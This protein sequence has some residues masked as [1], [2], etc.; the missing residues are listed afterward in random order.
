MDKPVAEGVEYQQ[1]GQKHTILARKEVIL[2]AGAIQTP[3]I[4]ELSGEL[5][6]REV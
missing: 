2:A 3:Q 4:L 6:D 1:E 5:A